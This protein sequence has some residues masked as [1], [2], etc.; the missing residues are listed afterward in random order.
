MSEGLFHVLELPFMPPILYL[1]YLPVDSASAESKRYRFTS[2]M[3][4]LGREDGNDVIILSSALSRQHARILPA[5]NHWAFCDQGSTN[6][7][8]LNS[9]K[10]EKDRLTLIRN[11][12]ELIL[13]DAH[14]TVY[15]VVGSENPGARYQRSLLVFNNAQ[16]HS[17]FPMESDLAEFLVGGKDSQLKVGDRRQFQIAVKDGELLLQIMEPTQPITL[18]GEIVST[19]QTL[20]DGDFILVGENSIC[21]NSSLKATEFYK[22]P[23]GS[24]DPLQV[25]DVDDSQGVDEA[26]AQ[27]VYQQLPPIMTARSSSPTWESKSRTEGSGSGQ[28]RRFIF[29][30]DADQAAGTVAW[31][32]EKNPFRDRPGTKGTKSKGASGN[33]GGFEMSL[34]G[35]MASVPG[36]SDDSF[37]KEQQRRVILGVTF[38]AFAL[39]LG[40]G[41]VVVLVLK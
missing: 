10:L 22:E 16:F 36:A 37:A 17:E 2:G 27:E 13:A 11:A 3:I 33:Q 21:V 31:S 40:L 30:E 4:T 14:F 1:D 20:K 24:Q 38:I 35:R 6:G 18:N 23:P 29:G 39:I 15:L 9:Q 8:W 32:S 19:D 34:S 26:G 28:N 5:G 25:Y 12:D 7:S 41:V